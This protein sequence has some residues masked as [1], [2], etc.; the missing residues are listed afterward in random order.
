MRR[1]LIV[2]YYYPPIAG[3][4]SIRLASFARHLPEFGWEPTV[5]SPATTPHPHDR[6]IPIPAANVVRSPA[7]EPSLIARAFSRGGGHEANGLSDPGTAR[8]AVKRFLYPDPQ[9]G[10]Y[11]GAVAAGLRALRKESFDVIFSSSFPITA[12]LVARTLSR[13]A[14]IPWVAEFRDPWSATLPLDHPHR[15]RAAGLEAKIANEASR[16]VMPTPTWAEHF[17]AVWGKEVEVVR[18][19][20]E[21]EPR[22]AQKPKTP[23]LTHLGSFYPDR[24]SLAPLWRA[25]SA[26]AL[27]AGEI[28]RVRFIGDLHPDVAAEADLAGVGHLAAATGQVPHTEAMRLLAESSMLFASGQGG[29]DPVARGWIP[30]KLYE[31]LATGLPI[32][33]LGDPESDAGAMLASQPGCFVLSDQ[34]A[35]ETDRAISSG[36]RQGTS[37]RDLAFLSRQAA[38]AELARVLDAAVTR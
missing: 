5:L 9:I 3:I 11:P 16:V 10:W 38:G 17:A 28:P 15:R 26:W 20:H 36:L 13:R 22:P 24:Q 25:L 1:I 4:G 32:L 30:A 6:S 37:E 27:E 14:T 19:G 23:T 29:E 12:H 2:A 8:S 34:D 21:L 7:L 31:Y 35:A 18:N 33:Y